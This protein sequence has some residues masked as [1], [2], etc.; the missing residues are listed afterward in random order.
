MAITVV[1]GEGWWAEALTKALFV[2]AAAAERDRGNRDTVMARMSELIGDE[3]VLAIF[4]DGAG[5]VLGD[6]GAFDLDSDRPAAVHA[7][8]AR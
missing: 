2:E 6:P 4:A 5:R 7:G 3:H 8:A 1:A